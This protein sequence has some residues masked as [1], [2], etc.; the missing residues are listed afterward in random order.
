M[1]CQTTCTL[2]TPRTKP[3]TELCTVVRAPLGAR[4]LRLLHHA[5]AR[6]GDPGN[7]PKIGET[8]ALGGAGGCIPVFVLYSLRGERA[9]RAP[10][11]AD[12]MR[13]YPYVRWL[14]YCEIAYFVTAHAAL[15]NTS[16]MLEWLDGVTEEEANTKLAALRSV[17]PA[18]VFREGSSPARPSAAEYVFSE[19]CHWAKR[20]GPADYGGSPQEASAAGPIAHGHAHGHRD[21]D[22][23]GLPVGGAHER[24]TM[25]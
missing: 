7:T 11:M 23:D 15:S 19:A 25:Y 10:A 9:Q 17:R 18:F 3:P 5:C 21:D 6:A 1:H 12:F 16:R 24:C 14:D 22:A 13:D 2:S 4:W 8:I 20:R